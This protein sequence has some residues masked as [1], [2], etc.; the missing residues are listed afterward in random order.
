VTLTSNAPESRADD[1]SQMTWY[2]EFYAGQ[3][4][5]DSALSIDFAPRIPGCSSPTKLP[6]KAAP[7][8]AR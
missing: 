8:Y 2:Q 7:Q 4:A 3:D 5:K 6:S 1:R